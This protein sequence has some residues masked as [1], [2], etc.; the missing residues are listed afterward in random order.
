M[1]TRLPLL[2]PQEYDG[3]EMRVVPCTNCSV[4][5]DAKQKRCVVPTGC[6]HL[7]IEPNAPECPI[8]D[9]CRHQV[10]LGDEP[11]AVRARGMICESALA[12]AGHPNPMEHPLGFNAD[13]VAT[14]EEVEQWLEEARAK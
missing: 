11:C 8:Q 6:E 5:W 3:I 12:F 1:R 7:P 14:P 10:Q 13:I 4:G 9:R 2:C